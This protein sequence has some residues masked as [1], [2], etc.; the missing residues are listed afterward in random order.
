MLMCILI[1]VCINKWNVNTCTDCLV[2]MSTDTVS[3]GDQGIYW[4]SWCPGKTEGNP[5]K[6]HCP[7]GSLEPGREPEQREPGHRQEIKWPTAMEVA[8]WKHLEKDLSGI[9]ET[10]LH[11][12][13]AEL[14]QC[15][16]VQ[17]VLKQ[18]YSNHWE[19]GC[20]P[21]AQ[22]KERD[23]AASEKVAPVSKAVEEGEARGEARC[24]AAVAIGWE[25]P[26]QPEKGW[27]HSQAQKTEGGREE[28]L[29]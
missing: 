28:L 24:E 22:S 12:L 4:F 2:H 6:L 5:G 10:L 27:A 25:I 3:L 26:G 29:L 21:K 18:V 17:V 1:K 20:W 8:P 13:E 14:Y 7:Q 16:L 15:H 9:L 19:A 11:R 23:W